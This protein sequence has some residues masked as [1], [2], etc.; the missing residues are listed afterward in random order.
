MIW[1]SLAIQLLIQCAL[2]I[3]CAENSEGSDGGEFQAT[4]GICW[5]QPPP[6]WWLPHSTRGG[7]ATTLWGRPGLWGYQSCVPGGST[8]Y[9]VHQQI[10]RLM[11]CYKESS[12]FKRTACPYHTYF[13]FLTYLLS[14]SVYLLKK[15]A[16]LCV[17]GSY[18]WTMLLSVLS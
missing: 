7:G 14:Q 5:A 10:A 15:S 8:E 11:G 9:T 18:V 16:C 6:V 13:F 12:L 17:I 4:L 1:V 3:H 2:W